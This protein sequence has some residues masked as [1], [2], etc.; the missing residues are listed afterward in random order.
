MVNLKILQS[1]WPRAFW[2]IF[3][4]LDFSQIWDLLGNIEKKLTAKLFNKF[5]SFS[6]LLGRGEEGCEKSFSKVSCS[7]T[8]DLI[9]VSDTMTKFR[10]T[11]DP[12]LRKYLD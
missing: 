6:L 11:N 1:D 2:P 9:W 12:I 8:L 4:K 3:Q 7:V 5:G 10:K